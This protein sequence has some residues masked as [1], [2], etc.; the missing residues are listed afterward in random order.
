[1]VA[2]GAKV[3][4]SGK[5]LAARWLARRDGDLICSKQQDPPSVRNPIGFDGK[6][7]ERKSVRRAIS[8]NLIRPHVYFTRRKRHGALCV[9]FVSWGNSERPQYFVGT[10]LVMPAL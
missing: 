8:R 10:I 1:M 4:I 9:D 6:H 5:S 7:I 3:R 2:S